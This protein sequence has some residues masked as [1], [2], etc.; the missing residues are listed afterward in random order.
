MTTT[1]LRA[2]RD[3]HMQIQSLTER[4]ARLRSALESCTP[5]PLSRMPKSRAASQDK[6][7]DDVIRL[8]ELE[9]RRRQQIIDL[10]LRLED[11]E[12]WI[13][14]LSPQ[15]ARVMRLRYVDGLSWRQVARRC[16]YSC[17]WVRHMHSDLLNELNKDNTK[18]HIPM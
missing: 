5:K 14:S 8:L 18:Q 15:Q 4:I 10:E 16:H 1:D 3:T 6:L 7:G 11:V 13:D 12:S 9:E 17:D 2:V